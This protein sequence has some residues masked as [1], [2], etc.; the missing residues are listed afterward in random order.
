M[1]TLI[2]VCCCKQTRGR[3][4][5]ES[6]HF[7]A[8]KKCSVIIDA[9]V[10]INRVVYGHCHFWVGQPSGPHTVS[11]GSSMFQFWCL[12]SLPGRSDWRATKRCRVTKSQSSTPAQ[13]KRKLTKPT[14]GSSILVSDQCWLL[15]SVEIKSSFPTIPFWKEIRNVGGTRYRSRSTGLT[16]ILIAHRWSSAAYCGL[17]SGQNWHMS[18]HYCQSFKYLR[19]LWQKCCWPVS[20][21]VQSITFGFI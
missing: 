3:P 21:V 14:E 2:T 4:T 9:G 6:L 18:Y 5:F 13:I 7:V 20:I 1:T 8:I 15:L 11:H 12:C 19:S 16:C 10:Q 17:K